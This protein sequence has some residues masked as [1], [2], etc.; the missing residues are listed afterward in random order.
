MASAFISP[1]A[2]F[3][4]DRISV[5]G[6]GFANNE[7]GITITYDGKVIDNTLVADSNGNWVS[8]FEVPADVN[9]SHTLTAFGCQHNL[10]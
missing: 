6:K 4:A 10:S 3:V 2:A 8:S 7:P 1:T 5:I 9:G